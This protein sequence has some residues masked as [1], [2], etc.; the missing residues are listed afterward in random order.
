[1]PSGS[2]LQRSREGSGKATTRVSDHGWYGEGV[3]ESAGSTADGSPVPAESSPTSTPESSRAGCA[4][5]LRTLHRELQAVELAD[6]EKART[7]LAA[8]QADLPTSG[9]APDLRTRLDVALA[10]VIAMPRPRV[11]SSLADAYEDASLSIGAALPRLRPVNVSRSLVHVAVGAAAIVVLRLG[12]ERTILWTATCALVSVWLLEGGRRVSRRW[13][14]RV[15][16]ALAAT[17]HSFERHAVTSGTWYATSLAALA[18]TLEAPAAAAS[19]AILAAADP[20][21]SYFGR[22]FGRHH[23]GPQRSVEGSVA[24]VVA[25]TLAASGA[26]ALFGVVPWGIA[27]AMAIAGALGELTSVGRIDDNLT[28][29]LA[30][31]LAAAL[32]G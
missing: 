28:I 6:A 14:A 13:R 24:F 29:P 21:A 2:V 5:V 1:M 30:A 11:T 7:R 22:R 3:S 20:S 19:V 9:L 27:L 12:D 10:E 23:L 32:L 17:A 18:W 25:G 31:G 8:V 15:D 4:A 26:F 16:T